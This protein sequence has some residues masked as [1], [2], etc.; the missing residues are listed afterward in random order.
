MNRDKC[1]TKKVVSLLDGHLDKNIGA[2]SSIVYP[3][4]GISVNQRDVMSTGL[5]GKHFGH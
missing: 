2:P 1:K 3:I 5:V 4:V